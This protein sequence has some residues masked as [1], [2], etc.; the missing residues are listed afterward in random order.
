ME[1]RE[2]ECVPPHLL[3]YATAVVLS[4]NK[5][6]DIPWGPEVKVCSAYNAP[7]NSSSLIWREL[8]AGGQGPR[9]VTPSQTAPQPCNDAW[10]KNCQVWARGE[11]GLAV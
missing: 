9:V 1:E 3:I 7:N 6:I 10:E 4:K 8:S 11:N 2:S 5:C